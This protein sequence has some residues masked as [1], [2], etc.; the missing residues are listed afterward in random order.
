MWDKKDAPAS[1][2]NMLPDAKRNETRTEFPN[3]MQAKSELI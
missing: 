2:P 1:T 3:I